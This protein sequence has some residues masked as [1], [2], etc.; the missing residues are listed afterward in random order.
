MFCERRNGTLKVNL[1]CVILQ[2]T[3][4]LQI[5]PVVILL[6][7]WLQEAIAVRDVGPHLHKHHI[8]RC[9]LMDPSLLTSLT[10]PSTVCNG[11]AVDVIMFFKHHKIDR[12]AVLQGLGADLTN[13]SDQVLGKKLNKVATNYLSLLKS[14]KRSGGLVMEK[15][16]AD[17]MFGAP[18]LIAPERTIASTTK[19]ERELDNAVQTLASLRRQLQEKDTLIQDTRSE[20]DELN[21]ALSEE[22]T[23][24]A[25]LSDECQKLTTQVNKQSDKIKRLKNTLHTTR[26]LQNIRETNYY[27]RNQRQEK[28]LKRREARLQQHM[29]GGCARL[30][31]RLRHEKKLA[32]TKSSNSKEQ[33]EICTQRAHNKEVE[34]TI[35]IAQLNQT[36]QDLMVAEPLLIVQLK[37][38][39][40]YF[41]QA[42]KTCIMAL[43][44]E[45][46]VAASRSGDVIKAVNNHAL[47]AQVP[48]GDLP[49]QHSALCFSDDARAISLAHVG[50]V[51]R[52]VD[53]YDY[54]VDGTGK[55]G[56]KYVCHA[57]NNS[58]GY[59]SVAKEDSSTLVEVAVNMLE[60]V[61]DHSEPG[62]EH[63]NFA[64]MLNGLT[65]AMCDCAAPMKSF[66][67]KLDEERRLLLQ[68]DEGINLL[69]CNAHFLLG[70]SSSIKKVLL[71]E[72]KNR[73]TPPPGYCRPGECLAFRCVS[74]THY[75]QYDQKIYRI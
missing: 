14:A 23:R 66:V 61:A 64:T 22:K 56:N 37:D 39:R 49:S 24:N 45:C 48:E 60:E 7:V 28:D 68:T 13:M 21:T 62:E 16:L 5:T 53:H 40:G 38:E 69:H 74:F 1:Y 52:E 8:Q 29:N 36:V 57:I 17:D 50:E 42:A 70:L 72:D 3:V 32:Q 6:F 11:M 71:E 46:E 9:H 54:H 65:S 31:S 44:A 4:L 75:C 30:I 58:I 12:R 18:A 35:K 2:L 10:L 33:L 26:T 47:Q 41:T 27:K 19:T 51:M 15:F 55:S 59:T 67:H 25:R 63:V 73:Q 20:K 43:V 34:L